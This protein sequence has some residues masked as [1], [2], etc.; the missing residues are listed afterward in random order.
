[1]LLVFKNHSNLSY[2]FNGMCVWHRQT[3]GCELVILKLW[4]GR[5]SQILISV[6]ER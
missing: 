1:M 6:V 2:N 5:Q 3:M 4:A